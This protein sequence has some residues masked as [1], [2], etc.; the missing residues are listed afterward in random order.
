LFLYIG[1]GYCYP[2][3]NYILLKSEF[4]YNQGKSKKWCVCVW[5]VGGRDARFMY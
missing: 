4:Q 3:D 5:V 1:F 2:Y